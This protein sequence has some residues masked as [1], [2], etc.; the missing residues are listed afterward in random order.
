VNW[1]Q[2]IKTVRWA[3]TIELC[4]HFFFINIFVLRKKKQKKQKTKN[5]IFLK[6][7]FT[8]MSHQNAFLNQKQKI[9]PKSHQQSY[10]NFPL[11]W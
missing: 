2:A 6:A 1:A 8:F 11:S 10:I 5:Q 9:P 3:V 7:T 4:W